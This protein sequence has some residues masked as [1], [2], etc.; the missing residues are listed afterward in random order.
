[1]SDNPGGKEAI[2]WG[3]RL[4]E[5]CRDQQISIYRWALL[6]FTQRAA[7]SPWFLLQAR[8]VDDFPDFKRHNKI[9]VFSN[10]CSL[11]KETKFEVLTVSSALV[12]EDSV[13]LGAGLI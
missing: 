9:K 8:P 5:L 2:T 1:M 6:K 10:N 7:I 13:C 12:S 11:R 3:V 4:T